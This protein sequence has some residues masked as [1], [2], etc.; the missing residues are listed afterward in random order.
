MSGALRRAAAQIRLRPSRLIGTLLTVAIGVGFACAALIFTAT[1]RDDLATRVSVSYGAADVVVIPM[2]DEPVTQLAADVAAAPGVA[3]ATPLY[4]ISVPF[5]GRASHGYLDLAVVPDAARLRWMTL[6]SGT[7]PTGSGQI[8]LTA[9]AA[10]ATHLPVGSA[11][12]LT[13]SD[14][15]TLPV[16]VVGLVDAS[17]SASFASES[18]GFGAPVLFSALRAGYAPMIA[19]VGQGGSTATDLAA[20]LATRLGDQG[21]VKTVVA[22]AADDVAGLS[23]KADALVLVLLTFAAVAMTVAGLVIANTVSILLTQRRR[24]IALLRCV[25]ATREQARNE[26]LGEL[27]IVGAAG[28]L[29]GVLLGLGAGWLTAHLT[30]LDSAGLRVPMLWLVVAVLIGVA[31]TV[32]AG[33]VPTWRAAAVQPVSALRPSGPADLGTGAR[34]ARA[35]GGVLVE[36]VGLAVLAGGIVNGSLMLALVGGAVSAIGVLML[37]RV[38]LPPLLR[39][40][41]VPARR[42]G[43]SGALAASNARRNPGRSA[44]AATAL[45]VGVG[46]IVMLQVGAASV[47]ASTDRAL[48]QRYPV[49]LTVD[50]GSSA[51]PAPVRDTIGSVGGVAR[52]V[53]IGGVAVSVDPSLGLG[54]DVRLIGVPSQAGEVVRGGLDAMDPGARPDGALPPIEVPGWVIA[55]GALD[56]GATLSVTV[57]GRPHRFTVTT[58][59]LGDV[60]DPTAVTLVT[61]ADELRAIAP[62]AAVVAVWAALAEGADPASVTGDLNTLVGPYSRVTVDGSVGERASLHSLLSTLT[63]VATGLLAVA[64]VIAIVG[65]GTTIGLSV[66][67]RTRESAL[68][69]A[70]G[71]RRGQLRLSLAVEA[72]LLAVLGAGVGIVLGVGYGWSG[73]AASFTMVGHELVLTV[74]WGSVGVVLL[75]AVAAGVLASVLPGR[76]AARAHPVAALAEE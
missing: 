42:W 27:A 35:A 59:H 3:A 10:T 30:G 12:T 57:D 76:R 41:A 32:L 45:I 69:R 75:V 66:V 40:L 16:T 55:G 33:A 72:L 11:V 20:A 65:I 51:L 36:L 6:T 63:T 47:S 14:G 70:L 38:V 19:V 17:R 1:Y 2:G 49:D 22:Q 8:V 28:S 53:P 39:A 34:R 9:A 23:G 13:G 15:A 18:L 25:G 50:A 68:L 74:P 4:D 60:G 43:I 37:T 31:L 71:L 21:L 24:Q 7:W 56:L 54:T 67:E 73:A 61:T 5:A 62:H 58:G 26:I 29:A 52:T 44:A 46:L 64:V 48:A